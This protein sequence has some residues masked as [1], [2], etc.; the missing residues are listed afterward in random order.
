MIATAEGAFIV[1][2]SHVGH[3]ELLPGLQQVF[4]GGRSGFGGVR[5]GVDVIAIEVDGVEGLNHITPCNPAGDD[6]GGMDS[7]GIGRQ[8]MRTIGLT[9]WR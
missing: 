3:A 1:K 6:V 2:L 7:I 8:G 5:G 9:A 4:T